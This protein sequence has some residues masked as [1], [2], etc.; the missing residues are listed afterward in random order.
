[1]KLIDLCGDEHPED[2]LFRLQQVSTRECEAILIDH[3][4]DLW[5]AKGEDTQVAKAHA[6]ELLRLSV[7]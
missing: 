7:K 4:L 2:F 3:V 1:M 6:E 5:Y